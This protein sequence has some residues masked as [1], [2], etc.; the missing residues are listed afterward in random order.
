MHSRGAATGGR[1]DRQASVGRVQ[2]NGLSR[3][4]S[5]EAG[6]RL[7]LRAPDPRGC[8][9]RGRGLRGPWGQ[10]WS[11]PVLR[12]EAHSPRQAPAASA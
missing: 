3:G 10:R 4:G 9:C 6:S 8:G 1:N 12:M 5:G 7:I 2:R 11:S